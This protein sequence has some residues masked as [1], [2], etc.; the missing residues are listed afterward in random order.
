MVFKIFQFILIFLFCFSC[1][2]KKSKVDNKSNNQVT[3][4]FNKSSVDHTCSH[5]KNKCDK[6]R[7]QLGRIA[8][9]LKESDKFDS[10]QKSIIND[11]DFQCSK[12]E[13]DG[14][15]LT[16]KSQ[17]FGIDKKMNVAFVTPCLFVN[18][19]VDSI[20]SQNKEGFFWFN[21][22]YINNCAEFCNLYATL[23]HIDEDNKRSSCSA[24]GMYMDHNDE[25]SQKDAILENIFTFKAELGIK[26]NFLRDVIETSTNNKQSLSLTGITSL[27]SGGIRKAIKP[28]AL[29]NIENQLKKIN[30]LNNKDLYDAYDKAKTVYDVTTSTSG[31]ITGKYTAIPEMN[32]K[33]YDLIVNKNSHL[34][35]VHNKQ[36]MLT[37]FRYPGYNRN[38]EMIRKQLNGGPAMYADSRGKLHSS[39]TDVN[40]LCQKADICNEDYLLV[41]KD[42]QLHPM[43]DGNLID[44]ENQILLKIDANGKLQRT[45]WPTP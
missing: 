4:N 17:T 30:R 38:P 6:Y 28:S 3:A 19:I 7:C 45:D 13:K 39:S 10:T 41:S 23:K 2:N 25:I 20:L 37:D 24:I 31:K 40:E 32:G 18:L 21:T 29:G 9:I 16:A 33:N 34:Q 5:M 44:K 22:H 26:K 43:E 36:V 27:G 35:A 12:N 42:G 11:L 8:I 1:K 14:T 15:I